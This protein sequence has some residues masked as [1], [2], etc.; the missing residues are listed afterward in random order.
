MDPSGGSRPEK[1]GGHLCKILKLTINE[2]S[3]P[4]PLD[5]PQPDPQSHVCTIF[6][7]LQASKQRK[8]PRYVPCQCLLDECISTDSPS[9]SGEQARGVTERHP[10]SARRYL[11]TG[12]AH[13]VLAAARAAPTPCTFTPRDAHL[14]LTAVRPTA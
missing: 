7:T 10:G 12:A 14:I 1:G 13:R 8:V 6:T 4:I 11:L 9:H 5:P 3:A 2:I